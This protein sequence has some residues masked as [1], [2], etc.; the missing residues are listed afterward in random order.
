M[1]NKETEPSAAARTTTSKKYWRLNPGNVD[2]V[3][4]D[5]L[6]AF[7]GAKDT[8]EDPAYK[9]ILA[10][11]GKG[12]VETFSGATH[13]ALTPAKHEDYEDFKDWSRGK[14]TEKP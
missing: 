3:T 13:L 10:P 12:S 9:K 5:A 1:A 6:K 11:L 8:R 2:D 14:A 7:P 4:I